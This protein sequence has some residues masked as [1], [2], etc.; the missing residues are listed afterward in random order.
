MVEDHPVHDRESGTDPRNAKVNGRAVCETS[1]GTI[2]FH[3][4]DPGERR[5]GDRRAA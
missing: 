2:Y 4:Y 5:R 3:A 1:R